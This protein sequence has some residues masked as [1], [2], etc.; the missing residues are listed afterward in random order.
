M[1]ERLQRAAVTLVLAALVG[2]GW[3][4]KRL[5]PWHPE[6]TVATSAPIVTLNGDRLALQ[7]PAAALAAEVGSYSE[8]VPAYLNS[9]FL[10]SRVMQQHNGTEVVLSQS[11]SDEKQVYRV[12]LVLPKDLLTALPFLS[13]LKDEGCISDYQLGYWSVSELEYRQAASQV[14]EASYSL[15]APMPFDA[16]DERDVIGPLTHF[17]LFKSRTD[18]RVRERIA[19]APAAPTL[20]QARRQAQDIIDVAR[21]YHLPLD[22]F[23]GIAA[24]ENNYLN[25]DGDLKHAI[26]KRRADPGDV[27]LERR[28]G[29]VLVSDYSM[30]EWQVSAESLRF[31][32]LLYMRDD[33]DYALLPARLRPSGDFRADAARPDVL[34]TY[35]GLLFR[36]LID[37][38]QGD[39]TLALGA[40]N[41]GSGDPQP[42]YSAS[43]AVAA[44]S[45][46][47]TVEEST[48]LA[49]WQV[50][51]VEIIPYSL[52]PQAAFRPTFTDTVSGDANEVI[53]EIADRVQR[54]RSAQRE[55]REVAESQPAAVDGRGN[56][57][58][59]SR[60]ASSV[61]GVHGNRAGFYTVAEPASA[62]NS[63]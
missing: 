31:A 35:A 19:T 50:I 20:A 6:P 10:W 41:G 38:F 33:R 17:I 1:R 12:Y 13:T 40:Y 30:G 8:E 15:P 56:G 42:A 29:R 9:Q 23:A 34:T 60:L 2:G 46:R 4:A 55:M 25:V 63:Q 49:G 51:P 26:W 14:L 45:A 43:V 11:A 3:A 18:V 7:V 54:L 62:G 48:A 5:W 44:A 28:R 36:H 47:R 58:L 61:S 52:P 57:A 27:V 53:D 32:H 24:Q 21:F 16:L 22:Q 59:T 39:L 37:H